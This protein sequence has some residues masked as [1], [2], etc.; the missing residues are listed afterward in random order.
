M[1]HIYN[2]FS[3]VFHGLQFWKKHFQQ[4]KETKLYWK[5]QGN[6]EFCFSDNFDS[7]YQIPVYL[8]RIEHVLK[9]CKSFETSFAG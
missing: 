6:F 5:G 9:C 8:W 3:N 1:Q 4:S 2:Y 7:Y